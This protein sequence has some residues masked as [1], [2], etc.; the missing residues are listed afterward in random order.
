MLKIEDIVEIRKAIGRPGYEIVFSKDKVIWLTKRRTI[1]SLLLLIKYGISSEADL[2][3]GSNRL[4]EVK[5]ILK[6]KYNETWIN[7]HYAD[8]NKPFSELWNEEGF[9]WIHPAQEKLN[10]NQQYVLKPED[11]DKLFILIKKAFRTSLSIKEQDEVMKKQ[12]GK[13]NLCGSSLLPKSKIQKNTYAKDRVR[14]VFDHRIPV[15]KGGDSTIDN[16]QALCFYCN[17]SKWQICNICHLDDCD[18]NCVLATPENNNI[19]S[20][21]KED[22]SDRLN[23]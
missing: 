3:R 23:R 4:L 22:I 21:T 20:P 12:N 1:I 13:C 10:G 19:I 15:E 6:G 17:K 11:H 9:T 16:Y 7:D 14:G 8:A 2:A 18:T 5:G